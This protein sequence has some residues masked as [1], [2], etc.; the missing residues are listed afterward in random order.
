[1]QRVTITLEEELAEAIDMLA[2][3]RG[4]QN[5]SEAIRDLVRKGLLESQARAE[6]GQCIASLTYVYDHESRDL[7]RRLAR[8]FHSHHDKTLASLHVHL[9]HE[10]CLEVAVLQGGRKHV[11][12]LA[13]SVTAERGVRYGRLAIM[14][15]AESGKAHRHSADEPPHTHFSVSDI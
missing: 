11:Q 15:V 5:R 14:P 10:N 1:M 2:L 6:S 12:Q 8:I 13:D 4:Y 7:S 9:D 3:E